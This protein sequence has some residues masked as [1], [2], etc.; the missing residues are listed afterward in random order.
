[1]SLWPTHAPSPTQTCWDFYHASKAGFE[2]LGEAATAGG[3]RAPALARQWHHFNHRDTAR[4]SLFQRLT[5]LHGLPGPP[6]LGGWAFWDRVVREP[7]S[8]RATELKA[9]AKFLHLA[10]S[11]GAAC[12][13]GWLTACV[14]WTAQGWLTRQRYLPAS[15]TSAFCCMHACT[16]PLHSLRT[17][18]LSHARPPCTC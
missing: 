11:S 8:L 18:T 3:I 5:A 6:D 14:C 2:A 1:M 13:A 16:R 7:D 10:V 17:L 15:A 9:A 12:A 4:E